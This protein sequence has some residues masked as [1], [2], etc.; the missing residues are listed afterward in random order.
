MTADDRREMLIEAAF[1][2]FARGGLHG[3]SADDIARRAGI[4]QPYLFRLFRTK[5][6]L[7]LAAVERCFDQTTDVF[8]DA[9]QGVEPAARLEAMGIAYCR[10]LRDRQKLMMQMQT[11]AACDDP[12]VRDLVQR[13]YGELFRFVEEIARADEES[14][15]AWFAT[16]M[17]LNV[18]AAMDLPGLNETWPRNLLGEMLDQW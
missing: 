16:G 14:V 9:A 13:R 4:S 7:F 11:Y 2:E 5:K 15:R 8:R 6:A 18:A 17:L 3:T 10:L 12:E 1:A